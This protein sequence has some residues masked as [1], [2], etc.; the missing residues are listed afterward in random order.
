MAA[1]RS[2]GGRVMPWVDMQ[3]LRVLLDGYAHG[4]LSIAGRGELAKLL[5]F[6]ANDLTIEIAA[7]RSAPQGGD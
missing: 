1:P 2:P 5:T 6:L 4:T 3:R 7:E